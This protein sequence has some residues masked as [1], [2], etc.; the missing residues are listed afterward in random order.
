MRRESPCPRT[1]RPTAAF[2]VLPLPVYLKRLAG[3]PYAC[4]DGCRSR[5]R[6]RSMVCW[7]C[8][9]N[10]H[11]GHRD[12]DGEQ[13]IDPSDAAPEPTRVFV[14]SD[15]SASAQLT[16]AGTTGRRRGCP[17]EGARS[18]N[19]REARKPRDSDQQHLL[20]R[21]VFNRI[22]PTLPAQGTSR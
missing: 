20:R 12:R 9:L 14:I 6:M 5:P 17:V 7:W 10:A 11:R 2:E 1:R 8:T 15:F 16:N 22:P 4:E 19:R 3:P 21:V 18:R 13:T